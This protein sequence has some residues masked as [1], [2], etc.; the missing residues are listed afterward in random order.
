MTNAAL[1]DHEAGRLA[2]A[3]T[4][5]AEVLAPNAEAWERA[6]AAPRAAYADRLEDVMTRGPK[7]K[8]P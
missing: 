8:R 5:A 4:F 3:E 6:K 7:K 2:A 1:S